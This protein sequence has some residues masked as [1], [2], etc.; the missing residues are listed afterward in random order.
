MTS[1]HSILI[2]PGVPGEPL[3]ADVATAFGTRLLPV[4]RGPADYS[5]DL[6]GTGLERGLSHDYVEDRGI[7]F[8]RY[9]VIASLWDFGGDGERERASAEHI[10]NRPAELRR[11]WPALVF[12]VQAVI[13]T[14][15]PPKREAFPPPPSGVM[16]EL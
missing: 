16:D 14:A 8:D 3:T 6:G 13:A 11:Y 9:Q 1:H 10:F 4:A 2:H 5:A 15:A 12:D 7:P